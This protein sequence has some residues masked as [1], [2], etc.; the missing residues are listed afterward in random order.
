MLLNK[1]KHKISDVK[2][3]QIFANPNLHHAISFGR[4]ATTQLNVQYTISHSHAT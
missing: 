3:E 2:S 1:V 4:D